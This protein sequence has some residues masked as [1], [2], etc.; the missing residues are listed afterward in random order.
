MASA[1]QLLDAM[2]TVASQAAATILAARSG[3]LTV[4]T[5]ADQSP[6]T[7]ADEA[8]ESILMEGIACLLPGVPIASEEAV[9]RSGC[10]PVDGDFILVDPIDGTREF[11]AG[12]DEFTINLALV[13]S[14]RPILGIVAAP[15][16]GLVWRTSAG[17]GAERIRLAP[18]APA[19]TASEPTPIRTRP[20][21]SESPI[22][23]VSRSHFDAQSEAFLARLPNIQRVSSGSAL[24]LCRLADGAADV[25]PRLGSS[26]EWDVAAG[27][28]V[29]AEAGGIVTTPAGEPLPY[30]GFADKFLVR[31]FIAWGD[32]S[33]AAKYHL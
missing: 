30:G 20:F 17:S 10:D 22:A 4:R 13:R 31:G 24:K 15:A 8:A 2:T 9:Y 6:V 23:I 12:R 32:P 16:L 25:Y 5:K 29:L 3:T 21:P 7:A 11:L 14:G 28:A 26:H 27:H 33:A 18:G 1:G 19:N